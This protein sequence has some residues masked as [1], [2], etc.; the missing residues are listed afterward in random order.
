M[1][2]VSADDSSQQVGSQPKSIDLLLGAA[3]TWHCST[4]IR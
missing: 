3:V 4:F 2:M 1:T